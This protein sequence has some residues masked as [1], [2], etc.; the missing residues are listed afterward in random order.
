MILIIIKTPNLSKKISA[1]ARGNGVTPRSG[2]WVKS[3][4]DYIDK[5]RVAS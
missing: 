1:R 3:F 5:L 4:L 2:P